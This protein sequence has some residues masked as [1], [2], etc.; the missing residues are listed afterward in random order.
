VQTQLDSVDNLIRRYQWIYGAEPPA[1]KPRREELAQ[2]YLR[3]YV[4]RWQEYLANGSVA[5]FA[6]PADAAVKLAMLGA[7]TSPLF[8]MLATASRETAMDSTSTIAQAFQ[9]LHQTVPPATDARGTTAA[10]LPYATALNLLASNLNL[11]GNASGPARDQALLQ[12]SSAAAEVKR[13]AAALAAGYTM[14]GD[15]A[16]TA[17][18]LQRLLRQPADFADALVSGLPA[19][20]LNAAGRSFCGN[21]SAVTRRFPFTPRAPDAMPDEVN[22][23][24][25]KEEGTLWSFYQD[26]LQSLV[27][28]QGRARPGARVSSGFARFFG[29]AAEF[30]NGAY[31]NGALSLV[32]DFQPEIPAGASEVILQVDGDAASFTPTN[33]ASRTFLWEAERAR[34]ARLVV[35]LDGERVTVAAGEGPW[36]PFRVFGAAEWRDSGPYRVEW[37]V[38]GRNATVVGTISFESGVPPLLRPSYLGALAQCVPQISN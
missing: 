32:F 4:R 10:A 38:P 28:P 7:P 11:L 34:E 21:Y 27:T 2:M 1:E 6:S 29:R 9:P 24:F 16:L 20:E 8:A 15:A 33:R 22:A 23:L 3:E 13:E 18:Q 19:A 14:S 26:A 12:A 30:S 5:R 31:R 17:S 36:A 35:V 37:R 25:L